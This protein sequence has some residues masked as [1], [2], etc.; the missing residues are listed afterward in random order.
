MMA[1]LSEAALY[2][3]AQFD[4]SEVF[5]EKFL[6]WPVAWSVC[7]FLIAQLLSPARIYARIFFDVLVVGLGVR[8]FMWR[9]FHTIE[10]E[11]GFVLVLQV[12][13]LL[14]ELLLFLNKILTLFQMSFPTDRTPEANQL[15]PA[16]HA[17]EPQPA[18]DI[19][20]PTYN[21]PLHILRRTIIGCQA[22]D[23][24]NKRIVLLDD[25]N[26][27]EVRAL[28]EQLGCKYISRS[29]NTGAKA[30]NLN[31]A[32]GG[33]DAPLLAVFDADFIPATNFLLR[34][35][36]FF[37]DDEVALV[38]TP[39]V[40]YEPEPIQRNLALT[41][42]INH[43]EELFFRLVQPGRDAFNACICHGTS[44]VIRRRAL[45]EIGGFPTESITED[46]F[47]SI[48]LQARG[49]KTLYLNEALS[50]GASPSDV[51]GFVQQR[52][53]W[54][55]GTWQVLLS[56]ANPL[57][58]KGLSF[59][60]RL[61]NF[62]GVLH[63]ASV[64]ASLVLF[65]LPLIFLLFDIS[66]MDARAPETLH[67]WL[68]YY[69]FYAISYSW[70]SQGMRSYLVSSI[71]TPILAYPA[72]ITMLRTIR[73]PFGAPFSVT[74]KGS[75]SGASRISWKILRPIAV[76]FVIY[77]IAL[78]HFVVSS[79]WIVR[80]PDSASIVLSWSVFNCIVLFIS[81]QACFNVVDRR[82]HSHMPFTLL[83]KLRADE[84]D[85][86]VSLA[87]LSEGGALLKLPDINPK[88]GLPPEFA[89]VEARS[90][91]TFELSIEEAGLENVQCIPVRVQNA[92]WGV[93]FTDLS[94][95]QQRKLIE[96]LYCKPG[97]WRSFRSNEA[98]G[99]YAM[100]RSFFRLDPLGESH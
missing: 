14:I 53:R 61:M 30:G 65:I 23:Y 55:Q 54:A 8:Y 97:T 51:A 7:A 22:I 70:F 74:A 28:T 57:S 78:I 59:V 69:A 64:A 10:P 93:E 71:Y 47:T 82:R 38:Q 11:N 43:E 67:Y 79:T 12:S 52:M 75:N 92:L 1:W 46:F 76:L 4:Y 88:D 50:A 42:E 2:V 60:Q 77:M 56:E 96:F 3:R 90:S 83:A 86:E 5:S 15:E 87:N 68:P 66:P 36:G 16:V 72:F 98:L 6:A 94:L 62:S 31:N 33:I 100:I 25:Q 48:K 99:A 17:M 58:I 40:F 80:D 39:Q 18:V 85:L 44:F 26:R 9:S 41:K 32:L 29:T 21:E 24:R 45:D 27:P 89:N 34:T 63:W 84:K 73:D 19:L 81:F 20:V 13:F 35:V 49:Y 95:A 37:Q 91:R